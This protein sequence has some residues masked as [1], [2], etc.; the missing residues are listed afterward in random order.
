MNVGVSELDSVEFPVVLTVGGAEEV[1]SSRTFDDGLCDHAAIFKAGQVE[2][3]ERVFPDIGGFDRELV[4][5][6][7]KV[8]EL[9]A[10]M[11]GRPGCESE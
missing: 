9:G 2:V 8:L 10:Q 4:G 6:P 11:D 1:T 5:L 7:V 3:T